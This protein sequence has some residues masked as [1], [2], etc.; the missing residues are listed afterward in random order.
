MTI[1]DPATTQRAWGFQLT[2]RLASSTSTLAGSF[3][4][5]DTNTFLMCA[6]ANL[7]TQL[8]VDWIEWK[9]PPAPMIG[10][11]TKKAQS[12]RR[13]LFGRAGEDDGALVHDV[14]AL[15]DARREREVL[16]HQQDRQTGAPQV[17]KDGAYLLDD[18]RCQTL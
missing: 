8:E 7:F 14:D 2:A 3:A 12:R 5:T 11:S 16:F 6:G 4:S 15:G 9:T 13:K 17:Q 18:L 10:G 1:S